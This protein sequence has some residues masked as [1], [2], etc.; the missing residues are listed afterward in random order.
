VKTT[1][2][3]AAWLTAVGLIVAAVLNAIANIAAMP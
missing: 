3:F 1:A 2:A